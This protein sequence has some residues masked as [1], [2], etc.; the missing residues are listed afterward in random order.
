[1]NKEATPI[2]YGYIAKG[3]GNLVLCEEK[4]ASL[5]HVFPLF[6]MTETDIERVAL[7]LYLRDGGSESLW[8]TQHHI[9]FAYNGEAQCVMNAL[10]NR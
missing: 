8:K 10:N 5:P 9:R 2:G 7:A 4:F 6:K 1:M 3:T